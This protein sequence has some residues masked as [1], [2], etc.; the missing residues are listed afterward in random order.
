[1][2]PKFMFSKSSPAIGL[3]LV[4]IGVA[5]FGYFFSSVESNVSILL[6]VFSTLI[7][8][9]GLFRAFQDYINRPT[10]NLH[11]F[12]LSVMIVFFSLSI[13]SPL[14]YDAFS[15]LSSPDNLGEFFVADLTYKEKSWG[16]FEQSSIEGRSTWYL[17]CLSVTILPAIISEVTGLNLE[18]IFSYIFPLIFSFIPVL[19]FLVVKEVF[20][21]KE[22]AGLSAILFTQLYRFTAPSM[23]RQNVGLL[24]LLLIMFVVFK[25]KTVS[26]KPRF[27]GFFVIFGL[28]VVISHYLIS[29]VLILIF[30]SALILMKLASKY[31]ILKEKVEMIS[32]TNVTYLIII[33]ISWMFYFNTNFFLTN[34]KTASNSLFALIG[35]VAPRY[36]SEVST[37]GRTSGTLVTSW[38]MLLTMLMVVGLLIFLFKK[39][40]NQKT[41]LWATIGFVLFTLLFITLVTPILSTIFGFQRVYSISAFFWVPFLAYILVKMKNRTFSTLLLVF[42]S[43]NLVLTLAIPSYD[44]LVI[45]TPENKVDPEIGLTQ[46]YNRITDVALF[47]WIGN[48]SSNTSISLDMRGYHSMYKAYPINPMI[49]DEPRFS[50]S[51]NFLA[52]TY[53]TLSY[54]L[55]WSREGIF[56][57]DLDQII[58]NSTVIYNNGQSIILAK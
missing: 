34:L 45:Y 1:M 15:G 26:Q 58:E 10:K 33:S 53:Y 46:I 18:L 51:S 57:V 39:K 30:I 20:R 19:V 49:V 55:W 17:S 36:I 28:G 56:T 7:M 38:Y 22:I 40:K 31:N 2:G 8:T 44:N 50:A 37:P 12:L 13:I 9:L 47:D 25:R 54:N 5:L 21:K 3:I 6:L 16:N 42:L 27:N 43:I 24:F 48:Q 4:I 41:F 29:Y 11:Y 14:R 52:L 32:I 35:L 23:I